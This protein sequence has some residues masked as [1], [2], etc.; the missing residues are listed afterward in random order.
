MKKNDT[1]VS[2]IIADDHELVREGLQAL[3][4]KEHDINLVGS[5]CNGRELVEMV[6]A[7][8]PSVVLTDLKMPL[9]DGIE[10]T[11]DIRAAFPFVEVIA[12]SMYDDETL[13]LDALEAG[14]CGYL[15]KNAD[16]S[17]ILRA[18]RQAFMHEQYYCKEISLKLARYL[19][20][21]RKP[22]QARV[23]FTAKESEV[24]RYICE[25]LTTEDIGKKLFLSK[26][27]IDGYRSD[28]LHKLNVKG[29]AGIVVYAMKHGLYDPG[30][31]S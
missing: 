9:M 23:K 30:E 16:K 24:I 21:T 31:Q 2:V 18:I 3:L 28:I 26:R 29:T 12:L 14:A 1:A 20:K 6:N 4:A 19:A 10:A 7:H 17:E 15:L 22:E 11:R 5:A 8:Q 13:V 25:G 27:T